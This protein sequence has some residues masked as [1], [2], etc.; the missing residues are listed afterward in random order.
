MQQLSLAAATVS[1]C[2][3][4]LLLQQLSLYCSSNVPRCD[5][6]VYRCWSISFC[7]SSVSFCCSGC[8][9]GCCSFIIV[10]PA[11]GVSMSAASVSLR[12]I[13]YF[14]LQQVSLCL[15]VL[16]CCRKARQNAPCVIFFDEIDALGVDREK[17]DASG[18][19]TAQTRCCCCYCCCFY[20]SLCCSL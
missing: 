18:V 6:S 3:N 7:C 20:W 16:F 14:V 11:A 4:C 17:G 19:R 1:C 8:A 12:V 15:S 9:Y 10:S 13:S 2:S 5:S